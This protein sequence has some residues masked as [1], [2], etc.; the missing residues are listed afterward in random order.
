MRRRRK[1]RYRQGKKEKKIQNKH[2]LLG[3]VSAL[4]LLYLLIKFR[5]FT[6]FFIVAVL[7][8]ILNYF[9]HLMDIHIH[10]GHIFFLSIVFSYA[11]DFKYGVAMIALA[12]IIPELLTG[13]A[14]SEM[15]VSAVLY[16]L[17][18]YISTLFSST[19]IVVLGVILTI[20]YGFLSFIIQKATGTSMVELL[21]ETGTEVVMN[22]V[23]FIGFA[24]LLLVL[25]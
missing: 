3:I 11:L 19:D 10:I 1:R 6:V 20:V 14:D 22:L 9:I 21:T 4:T 5:S 23:Y 8:G 2:I 25:I 18:S 12:H 7:A 15:I 13:H 17:L 24:K 16:G